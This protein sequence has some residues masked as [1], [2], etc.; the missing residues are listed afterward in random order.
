[1]IPGQSAAV[2]ISASAS[3]PPGLYI[4]TISGSAGGVVRN[5]N[6][7][8]TVFEPGHQAGM[9]V[10][11]TNTVGNTFQG[12]QS[13][14]T[15]STG[16]LHLCFLDDTASP[17][18]L[19]MYYQQSSDGGNTFTAPILIGGASTGQ[20]QVS[21]GKLRREAK[22]AKDEKPKIVT[23]LASAPP[24]ATGSSSAF[25]PT[26]LYSIFAA[27]SQPAIAVDLGGNIYISVTGANF[28]KNKLVGEVLLYKSTDGGQ[29]FS[30]PAV[31]VTNSC[32][33]EIFAQAIRTG[34]SG[35]IVIAYVPLCGG[36]STGSVFVTMSS[37]G[38]ATFSSPQEVSGKD[39]L[40]PS[41]DLPVHI[42]FDSKGGIYV[43]YSSFPV[44]KRSPYGVNL[45][46]ASD[47]VHFA[48]PTTV[49]Q[50]DLTE[51]GQ[52][53]LFDQDASTPDL[54]IDPNDNL[55]VSFIGAWA[56]VR[57]RVLPAQEA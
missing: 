12:D 6:L 42:A 24:S 55:F 38:G 29:T 10:N 54:V 8:L 56:P 27:T 23:S 17:G 39:L 41:S 43:L 46:V 33:Q 47:G 21:S 20:N 19:Q 44:S 32:D 4:V 51:P 14:T 16:K 35:N 49:Y 13:M 22:E 37:D 5:T 7:S 45:A 25:A 2:Q 31:A 30:A 18:T 48:P 26:T 57:L 36:H 9:P 28:V 50:Y 3:T 1:V 52:Q 40:A 15:D 34:I 11:A 53:L